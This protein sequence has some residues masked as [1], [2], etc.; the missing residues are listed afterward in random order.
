MIIDFHRSFGHRLKG[1]IERYQFVVGILD[2]KPH[3]LAK[4]SPPGFLGEDN[5]TSYAGGPVRKTSRT[6]SGLSIADVSQLN[7]ERL[8]FN[9]ILK[10][11]Q[12]QGADIIKFTTEFLKLCFERSSVK[13]V[14]NLIQ[15]IVR[16][17]ILRQ[18]YGPNKRITEMTKGFNRNMIDTGQ[19]FKNIKANVIRKGR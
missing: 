1:R 18:D 12:D 11:F 4:E 10:P 2:D 19:L 13:R 14:V 5:I 8:G 15:A 9:Y 6:A 17:P 16:N 3:R 7:R